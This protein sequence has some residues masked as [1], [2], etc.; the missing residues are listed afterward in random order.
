MEVDEGRTRGARTQKIHP[1]NERP[2]GQ[3]NQYK[4][5]LFGGD[6]TLEV[7]GKI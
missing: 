6:L 7:N 5:T 3:W 1:T 2:I 4:I